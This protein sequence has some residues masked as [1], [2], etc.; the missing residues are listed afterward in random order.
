MNSDLTYKLM[1]LEDAICERERG[2]APG[3][4]LILIPHDRAEDVH[5][6]RDGKPTEISIALAVDLALVERGQGAQ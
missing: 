3:Y 2:G 6:S 1:Q 5:V 4:T